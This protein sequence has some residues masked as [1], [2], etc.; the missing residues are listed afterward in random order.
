[1]S[2]SQM[3]LSISIKKLKDLDMPEDDTFCDAFKK[4]LGMIF[5]HAGD[6]IDM[7][8]LDILLKL[9]NLLYTGAK[10]AFPVYMSASMVQR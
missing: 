6:A 8:G 1:M 5:Q 4:H 9:R 10:V 7:W 2:L 3:S